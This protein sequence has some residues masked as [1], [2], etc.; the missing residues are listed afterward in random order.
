MH[1][2]SCM[3]LATHTDVWRKILNFVLHFFFRSIH[4]KCI[5]TGCSAVADTSTVQRTCTPF[6]SCRTYAYVVHIRNER[7]ST[8]RN[9]TFYK[10]EHM[11]RFSQTIQ[12]TFSSNQTISG[13]ISL[14]SPFPLLSSPPSASPLSQSLS[15]T[16]ADSLL[17]CKPNVLSTVQREYTKR[18]VQLE[19]ECVVAIFKW[20]GSGD[21]CG[22][23]REIFKI[24]SRAINVFAFHWL[25]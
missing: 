25:C 12:L 22:C 4:I 6:N 9:E 1:H 11:F 21:Q 19:N 24:N 8:Q 5:C 16:P 17:L 7:E 2:A 14:F 15:R 13:L 20:N 3:G 18:H 10:P 23:T